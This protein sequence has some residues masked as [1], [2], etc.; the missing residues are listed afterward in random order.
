M[1]SLLERLRDAA[2]SHDA[3]R[4]AALFAE[5][6]RSDQPLHPGRAFTGRAQVLANWSSVFEGV[7]DFTAE[8]VDSTVDGQTEWGEWSWHGQHPDG[9]SFAMRGVTVM[10]V[11]DG[12]V[13]EA[14]LY[15]E[16][17]ELGGA[18]IDAAVRDLYQP[19]AAQAP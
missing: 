5:D 16:P 9:T 13:A 10:V 14:R 2:N 12:Q 17:V 6:Y 15:L 11:R 8:L 18:D 3:A 7:P 19:P 1:S 4:V